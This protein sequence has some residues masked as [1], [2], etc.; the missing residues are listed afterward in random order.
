MTGLAACTDAGLVPVPPLLLGWTW[1]PMQQINACM[2]WGLH[3]CWTD[4]SHPY[5]CRVGPSSLLNI[6]EA[7]W[8]GPGDS[9]S[10][11]VVSGSPRNGFETCAAAGLVPAARTMGLKPAWLATWVIGSRVVQL[12]VWSQWP[13]QLLGWPSSS[14]E[15]PGWSKAK[16]WPAE[17]WVVG[18]RNVSP[19]AR[20]C[21]P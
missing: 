7:S 12:L 9:R 21:G 16:I 5:G 11:W 8:A 14:C 20:F 10:C 13:I 3:G 1:R 18:M 4:P 17:G 15:L 19:W 6:D 2:V